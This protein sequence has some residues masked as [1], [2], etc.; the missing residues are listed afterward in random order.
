MISFAASEAA[1][2]REEAAKRV[3]AI[4]STHRIGVI[5]G[6]LEWA[7]PL[8]DGATSTS[9]IIS[10]G[11]S[12]VD[13][14]Q[15]NG[16][17]GD[18]RHAPGSARRVC[19]AAML[20]GPDGLLMLHHR[21][22]VLIDEEIAAGLSVGGVYAGSGG[23]EVMGELA[24]AEGSLGEADSCSTRAECEEP[25]SVP[26]TW[27]GGMRVGIL[28]CADIELPEPAAA[29]AAAGADLLAVVACAYMPESAG[30]VASRAQLVARDHP[31]GVLEQPAWIGA[32]AHAA[33]H[34]IFVAYVNQARGMARG[35]PGTDEAASGTL[36]GGCSRLLAPDGRDVVAVAEKA[37]EAIAYATLGTRVL[38]RLAWDGSALHDA[39]PFILPRPPAAPAA[40]GHRCTTELERALAT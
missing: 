30:A 20:V 19:N 10:A 16:S 34:G 23:V 24:S 11:S 38:D 4:A 32:A 15:R 27:L 17:R 8:S 9:P 36:Q 29:V 28:I 22:C 40:R 7:D 26:L 2:R 1:V 18:A 5:V 37:T 39:V 13:R 6:Y 14:A 35:N 25:C 3:G 33:R 12:P 21:K 31:E